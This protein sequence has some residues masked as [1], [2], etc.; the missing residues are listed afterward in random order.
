MKPEKIK[1]DGDIKIIWNQLAL[2]GHTR[3]PE[4]SIYVMSRNMRMPSGD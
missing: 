3:L 4:H 2:V 1:L